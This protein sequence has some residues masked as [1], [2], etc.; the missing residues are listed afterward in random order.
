MTDKIH[1]TDLWQKLNTSGL[2]N[3]KLLTTLTYLNN[4]E[5]EEELTVRL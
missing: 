5:N 1:D 2:Y 3:L 4:S